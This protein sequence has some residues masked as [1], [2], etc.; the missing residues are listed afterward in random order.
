MGFAVVPNLLERFSKVQN[1]LD[2]K[3]FIAICKRPADLPFESNEEAAKVLKSAA[4]AGQVF[5]LRALVYAESNCTDGS[6]RQYVLD[7]LGNE[8]LLNH[9]AELIEA[10]FWENKWKD[11]PKLAEMENEEWFAIECKDSKCK[12]DR[13][14]YFYKKRVALTTAKIPAKYEV[15]RKFLLDGLKSDL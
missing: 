2:L 7:I 12:K 4:R 1:E 8:I 9:T 14:T 13:K 11:Y 6:S 5:Q 15:V 3:S 10:L